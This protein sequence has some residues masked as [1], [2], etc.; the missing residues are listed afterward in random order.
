[1]GVLAAVVGIALLR[2]RP[3]IRATLGAWLIAG[4]AGIVLSGSYFAPYVIELV[5]VAAVGAAMACARRPLVGVVALFALAAPALL[6]TLRAG[7]HDS[8]DAYHREARTMGEYVH[9][10][11]R[12]G[13]TAYVLYAR[14]RAL[15]QRAPVAIPL[16][17]GAHD[18]RDPGRQA[19]TAGAAP[20]ARRPT[21][22]ID[23]DHEN[24]FGLDPRGTT[25]ALLRR[26]YRRVATV[27]GHA[28][29]LA[30]GSS[31]KPAPRTLGRCTLLP[32]GAG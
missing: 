13:Q 5:P 20:R 10:R 12:P 25:G 29:L 18:A 17:L 4:L 24:G 21:W 3:E 30:R 26:H 6:P 9:L 8:A 16:S 2:A 1:V 19:A 14:E 7:V 27:C 32:S 15:L 28:I 22:I 11:A 23:Q 31:A